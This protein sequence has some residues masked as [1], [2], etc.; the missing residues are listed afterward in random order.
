MSIQ[1]RPLLVHYQRTG[2]WVALVALVLPICG[3]VGLA[4]ASITGIIRGG[5]GVPGVDSGVFLYI[6]HALL[7]GQ[8]PYK[9]VWDHKSPGIYFIDALGLWLGRGSLWGVW[10]LEVISL[11]LSGWLTYGAIRRDFGAVPALFGALAWVCSVPLVCNG[12]NVTEE[13]ALL[14]AQC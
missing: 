9:D 4:A 10:L 3:L 14:P 11:A 6:G 12:G 13:W 2:T 5:Q 7:I 8:V 1:A